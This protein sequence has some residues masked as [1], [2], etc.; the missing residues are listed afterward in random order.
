MDWLD[1]YDF[2]I[3]Y[4]PYL[5]G[6]DLDICRDRP[7]H[8]TIPILQWR[9]LLTNFLDNQDLMPYLRA[10]VQDGTYGTYGDHITLQ[11]CTVIY[12]VQFMVLSSL[13]PA[14][15]SIISMTGRYNEHIPTLY[16]NHL[17]EGQGKHYLSIEG[18]IEGVRWGR[19]ESQLCLT[20]RVVITRGQGHPAAARVV[21]SCPSSERRLV[22]LWMRQRM[23][24]YWRVTLLPAM[25]CQLEETNVSSQWSWAFF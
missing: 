9:S 12:N 11:R 5:N 21:A 14:A 13:G 23:Y 4:N 24:S 16:V 22:S 3:Q 20:E 6:W 18:S 8:W 17:E 10:I 19:G 15:T 2:S 1:R 7:R 25:N